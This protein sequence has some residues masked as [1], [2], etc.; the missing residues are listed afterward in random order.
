MARQT[1]RLEQHADAVITLRRLPDWPARLVQFFN[2]T[3]SEP[4]AYG[5]MDCAAFA[6]RGVDAM[7]GT[8]HA[9]ALVGAY[10]DAEGSFAYC[11]GRGWD[12]L[13]DALRSFGCTPLRSPL[14]AQRGDVLY[15]GPRKP[16]FDKHVPKVGALFLQVGG[17]AYGSIERGLFACTLQ[18]AAVAGARAWAVGR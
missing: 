1:E 12:T 16:T 6:L 4:F 18:A 3:R 2:A 7:C 9:A 11:A 5:T 10:D 14:H 8:S 13:E 17:T 15:L